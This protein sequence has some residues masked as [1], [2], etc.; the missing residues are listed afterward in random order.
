MPTLIINIPDPQT[1][2]AL[3]KASGQ[4]PSDAKVTLKRR[5]NGVQM[6]I[7]K[8][9]ITDSISRRNKMSYIDKIDYLF[10]KKL[11]EG[12]Y[13]YHN[14]PT[15]ANKKRNKRSHNHKKVEESQYKTYV[16]PTQSLKADKGKIEPS[17]K[18]TGKARVTDLAE[19]P[20]AIVS[21]TSTSGDDDEGFIRKSTTF[22]MK[23][24]EALEGIAT[25]EDV[26]PQELIGRFMEALDSAG[27]KLG[28]GSIKAM[29]KE[30]GINIA[31]SKDKQA[32][33]LYSINKQTNAAQPMM[34]IPIDSLSENSKFEEAIFNCIDYARGDA[35]GAFKQRQEAMRDQEGVVRE[36]V[37]QVG[38]DTLKADQQAALAQQAGAKIARNV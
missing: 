24:V 14:P 22:K 18:S 20:S 1:V 4:V 6:S 29:L 19:K 10:D 32:L 13:R 31:Q 36:I 34:R 16:S 5:R 7:D 25:P 23:L 30:Q 3:L 12:Q 37:T 8:K 11:S 28:V 15:N 27:Q 38:P 9:G 33:I 2:K 21:I 35:P 17:T 26:Q